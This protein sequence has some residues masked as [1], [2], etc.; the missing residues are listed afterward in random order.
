MFYKSRKLNIIRRRV[1]T[2]IQIII[3][4][5]FDLIKLVLLPLWLVIKLIKMPFRLAGRTFSN[6]QRKRRKRNA[7]NKYKRSKRVCT[8][9]NPD[10][11]IEN[12]RYVKNNDKYLTVQSLSKD[13]QSLLNQINDPLGGI[14]NIQD[15]HSRFIQKNAKNRLQCLEDNVDMLLNKLS[16]IDEE[17]FKQRI[18]ALEDKLFRNKL[19]EFMQKDSDLTFLPSEY[20]SSDEQSKAEEDWDKRAREAYED[21]MSEPRRRHD[22]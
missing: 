14:K 19:N 9:N 15:E 21:Q 10:F 4:S 6:K 20:V 18:T 1:T 8:Y 7:M 12:G 5:V 2:I 11:K 22:D 13:V 16:I 17:H 3:A